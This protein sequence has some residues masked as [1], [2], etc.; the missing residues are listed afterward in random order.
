MASAAVLSPLRSYVL[1]HQ[2]E[3]LSWMDNVVIKD[4]KP[5]EARRRRALAK[6]KE[7]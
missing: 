4:A 6:V 5:E 3:Y 2:G 7:C 1:H